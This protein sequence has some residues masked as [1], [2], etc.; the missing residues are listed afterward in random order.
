MPQR[1]LL[2]VPL[3]DIKPVR[4]LSCLSLLQAAL[5]AMDEASKLERVKQ[6]RRESASRSRAR[7]NAYMKELE[8]RALAAYDAD[9]CCS[10]SSSS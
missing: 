2:S 10:R 7:K 9:D 3:L 5:A 6:K 4:V 1:L 8:V